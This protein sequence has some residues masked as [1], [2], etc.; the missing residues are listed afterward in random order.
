MAWI[1]VHETIKGPKLREFRKQLGCSEFEA[2]GV[3]IYLWLWGLDN[4]TKDGLILSADEDD[5]VQF[6]S[7]AGAG[8]PLEPKKIVKALFDSGWLDWTESG[9]YIH[10]WD[11]WQEQWYKVKESRERDARRKRESRRHILYSVENSYLD[12]EV[13]PQERER[14]D[15]AVAMFYVLKD[16]V[17]RLSVD[18]ANLE[19][20]CRVVDAIYAANDVRRQMA[21]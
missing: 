20:D 9:I 6:V 1:S 3:L 5:I 10:D 16:A 14:A 13:E 12:I 2:T 19:G 21:P 17:D 7:Y 18:L 8:C 11:V 15:M 4:A